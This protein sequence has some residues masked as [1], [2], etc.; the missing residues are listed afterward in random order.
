MSLQNPNRGL[1]IELTS[2]LPS[3]FDDKDISLLFS[4]LGIIPYFGNN[5]QTSQVILQHFADQYEYSVTNRACINSIRDNSFQGNVKLK[6]RSLLGIETP[7]ETTDIPL[8]ELISV[9][10]TAKKLGFT[11]PEI[12]ELTRQLHINWANSGN[13]Y[14]ELRIAKVAGVV[15]V[16]MQS[17]PFQNIA[18]KIEKDASGK[19]IDD[20]TQ[21]F[22]ISDTMTREYI[23][24]FPP[25]IVH[26]FPHFSEVDNNTIA[27][28]FH[29]KNQTDKSPY[30]GRPDSIS[31]YIYKFQELFTAQKLVTVSKQDLVALY[32]LLTE[33][34]LDNG[35][36]DAEKEKKDAQFISD[37]RQLTTLNPSGKAKTLVNLEY[38]NGG[39]AP[40]LVEMNIVRDT[41]W[42]MAVSNESASKIIQPHNW[43]PELIGQKVASN[44]I[45]KDSAL[46]NIYIAAYYGRIQPLQAQFSDFWTKVFEQI[47]IAAGTNLADYQIEFPSVI[48]KLIEE[49]K[50]AAI[51]TPAVINTPAA[52]GT[53]N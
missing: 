7:Q 37:L 30:Y 19:M 8:S 17:I 2:P 51:I 4:E 53:T 35:Q 43:F 18:Y 42:F 44:G 47:D 33:K 16:S 24:K 36:S 5:D 26:A 25:R 22:I 9:V 27:T 31:S 3:T 49:T 15:K 13:G 28:V 10:E 40:Q 34:E 12:T 1:N 32:L 14:L 50:A 23:A 11:Y 48:K 46:L 52:N 39:K 38:P 29:I 21:K 6:K 45:G 20:G 41:N